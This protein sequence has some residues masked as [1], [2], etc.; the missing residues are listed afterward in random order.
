MTTHVLSLCLR[1]KHTP[2]AAAAHC[3]PL[4]NPPAAASGDDGQGPGD[5]DEEPSHGAR[6]PTPPPPRG[7]TRP[8]PIHKPTQLRQHKGTWEGTAACVPKKKKG[9]TL[10]AKQNK[11]GNRG[12]GRCK[13]CKDTLPLPLPPPPPP[14]KKKR[15]KHPE[16]VQILQYVLQI[17]YFCPLGEASQTQ[18]LD[19]AKQNRSSTNQ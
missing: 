14:K 19:A 6:L 17:F 12:G 13:V 1:H 18:D 10:T 3:R 4:P 16:S 5:E 15:K 9:H 7:C 11:A 8:A 2:L